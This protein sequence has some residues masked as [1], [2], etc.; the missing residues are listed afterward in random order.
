MDGHHFVAEKEMM[1]VNKTLLLGVGENLPKSRYCCLHV[2]TLYHWN[3][4]TS[5]DTSDFLS[6]M[7]L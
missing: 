3:N 4:W 5:N 1:Q 2:M 7:W 6:V